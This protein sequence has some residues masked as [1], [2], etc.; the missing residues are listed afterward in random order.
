VR[1][2]RRPVLALA[3]AA[4]TVAPAGALAQATGQ[5]T[6]Q[7]VFRAALLRDARTTTAIKGLLR[8]GAAFVSPK[9]QFADLTG[10]GK[11]DAVVAVEDGGAAGAFAAY[12][13]STQ[14]S[15]SSR[16][17]VIFAS[18]GLYRAQLRISGA[19]LTVA[20]PAYAAGD[21]L[22]CPAKRTERDYAWSASART[23]TRRA[24][25]TLPGA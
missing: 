19:T 16:L 24:T 25:R 14:G 20:T 11:A 5:E 21:D 18:Q 2:V 17:H 1:L 13:L 3:L 22:C 15:Q 9:P 23:L 4:L 10:D 8:A 6:P 12:V 7:E